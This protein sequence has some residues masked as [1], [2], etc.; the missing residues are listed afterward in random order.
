MIFK[1][2]FQLEAQ[3]AVDL[4]TR[5]RELECIVRAVFV[6]SRGFISELT[7]LLSS[8]HTDIDQGDYDKRTV[9]HLVVCNGHLDMVRFLVD[10][11]CADVNVKDRYGN[12]PLC[13]AI[14]HEHEVRKHYPYSPVLCTTEKSLLTS[15]YYI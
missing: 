13:D 8:H 12:T 2:A 3:R 1:G 9:L 7:T 5:K 4:A 15:L 11:L 10:I 14:R 6:G